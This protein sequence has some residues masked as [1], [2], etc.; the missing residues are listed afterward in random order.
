M[1]KAKCQDYKQIWDK[2]TSLDEFCK[3]LREKGIEKKSEN[4]RLKD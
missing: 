4:L 1:T 2:L 3:C